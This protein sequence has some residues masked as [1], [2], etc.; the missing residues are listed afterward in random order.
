MDAV[1]CILCKQGLQGKKHSFTMA[2]GLHMVHVHQKCLRAAGN[3][4]KER[5]QVV[6]DAYR[7][8][9]TARLQTADVLTMADAL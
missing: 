2:G 9:K 8:E 7:A 4:R 1:M 6:C 5:F 3:R